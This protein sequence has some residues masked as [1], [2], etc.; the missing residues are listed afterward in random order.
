MK[1]DISALEARYRGALGEVKGADEAVRGYKRANDALIKTQKAQRE[2][3]QELTVRADEV[4]QQCSTQV[5]EMEQQIR[6]LS[7]YTRARTQLEASPLKGEI[8]DG[9]VTQGTS[10]STPQHPNQSSKKKTPKSSKK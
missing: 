1:I 2:R 3:V 5:A 6:D 10:Q 8:Q 4:R 9:T 7:F